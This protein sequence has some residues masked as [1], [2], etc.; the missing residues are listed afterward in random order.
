M[1]K[2]DERK[3]AVPATKSIASETVG[4]KLRNV[5]VRTVMTTERINAM[6]RGD[7]DIG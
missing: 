5:T 7:K 4:T 3:H 1:K 6:R 2:N